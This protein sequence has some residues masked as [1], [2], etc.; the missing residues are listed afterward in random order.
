[1]ICDSQVVDIMVQ[2]TPAEIPCTTFS[3]LLAR[4]KGDLETFRRGAEAVK[5][6]KPGNR[7]LIAEGCTHHASDDDIG[8]VKIP[9]MLEKKQVANLSSPSAPDTISPPI[10][11]STNSYSTAGGVCSTAGNFCAALNL[12]QQRECLLSITA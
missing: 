4:I 7:V 9:R 10:C 12:Q 11:L 6:L 2:E 3:I 5:K 8:R 1:M